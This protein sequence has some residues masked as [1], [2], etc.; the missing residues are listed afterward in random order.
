VPVGT[1]EKA[2]GP[3]QA[4]GPSGGPDRALRGAG[5]LKTQRP[6]A[7]ALGAMEPEKRRSAGL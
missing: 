2:F 4:S 1:R 3:P 7:E 6:A 5:F